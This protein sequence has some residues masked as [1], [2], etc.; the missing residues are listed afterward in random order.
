MTSDNPQKEPDPRQHERN[1]TLNWVRWDHRKHENN[2]GGI[3]D[4]SPSG[5]FLTPLGTMPDSIESG[6]QIWIVLRV[7][8]KDHVLS[9]TVR[10]RGVSAEH[11]EPGFGLEFDEKSKQIAEELCLQMAENGL[12]FVPSI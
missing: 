11:G 4:I 10:W 8:E 12:F 3:Y 1:K 9:A 5:T 6:D 7:D 2:E